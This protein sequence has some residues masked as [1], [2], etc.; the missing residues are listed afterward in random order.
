MPYSKSHDVTISGYNFVFSVIKTSL[1]SVIC[2]KSQ[3]PS[4]GLHS[5]C[6]MKLW[7]QEEGMDLQNPCRFE[8]EWALQLTG[9][10]TCPILLVV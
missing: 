10:S 5:I 7:K 4:P 6:L 8:V 2:H 3:L 9:D 1:I